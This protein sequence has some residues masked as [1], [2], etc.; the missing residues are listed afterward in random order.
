[1]A[2]EG[3]LG[4]GRLGFVGVGKIGRPMAEQLLRAGFDLMVFD[5]D[6]AARAAFEGSGAVVAGSLGEL[7][8]AC[9]VICLCLPGPAEVEEVVFGDS[10][11]ESTIREG[12]LLIDHTTS[13]SGVVREVGER[14]RARGAAFVDAPISGGVE[15]AAEGTLTALVGG[16][17]ADV[18]RATPF[19][20]AFSSE[21][22]HVGELGAGTVAKLMNNLAAFSLDQVIAECLTIGVKAGIDPDRLMGALQRAAIGKGGNLQVRL[23]ETYMRGDFEPRFALKTAHKDIR[24]AV[25]L[26]DEVGVP[27]RLARA[28]LGEMDEALSEG[29]GD[30]DASI[31]MTLQ[32]KRAGVEISS[33]SV[34]G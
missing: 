17:L 13:S 4:A 5:V 25:E 18:S 20:E 15:G 2:L 9:G 14:L 6:V 24:L 10:G 3:R 30:R 8:S 22:V 33:R 11:V 32:E 26:A 12:S 21:V 19:L 23:P 29:L 1:M 34:D 27:V 7:V 31:V 28:V 16:E